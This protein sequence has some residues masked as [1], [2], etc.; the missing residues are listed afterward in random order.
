MDEP[1]T[2][3]EALGDPPLQAS[4]LDHPNASNDRQS[5]MYRFG[6]AFLNALKPLSFWNDGKGHQV[7]E[8]PRKIA[9]ERAWAELKA[10]GF[11]GCKSTN[12]LHIN[13]V[14]SELS[15]RARRS[16]HGASPINARFTDDL[17]TCN[18]QSSKDCQKDTTSS[19][20][21]PLYRSVTPSSTHRRRPSSLLRVPSLQIIHKASSYLQLPAKDNSLSGQ[22]GGHDV[23]A[24]PSSTNIPSSLR[25]E[26]SRK[27]LAKHQ[28]LSKRVSDLETQLEDAKKQL[29][30][31]SASPVPPQGPTQ[32]P[33]HVRRKAFVP[34]L[35]PSLPSERLI[36]EKL[37]SLPAR[38]GA[39]T[40]HT[41]ANNE[42][43]ALHEQLVEPHVPSTPQSKVIGSA[44]LEAASQL[45]RE[46]VD[47][48]QSHSSARKRK[49]NQG[50]PS[51]TE[52]IISMETPTTIPTSKRQKSLRPAE[53]PRK[54]KL[55]EAPSSPLH[56]EPIVPPLPAGGIQSS[57]LK[58]LLSDSQSRPSTLA[59]PRRSPAKGSSRS[60]LKSPSNL[61]GPRSSS[62]ATSQVY[63]MR[64]PLGTLSASNINILPPVLE[65]SSTAG[66]GPVKRPQPQT[67]KRT[68]S[69]PVIP[70]E[71]F[72]WPEDV[73]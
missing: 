4:N 26:P 43:T 18:D 39:S 36:N 70:K 8:D 54:A 15:S 34:G 9:A 68:T 6:R 63:G 29:R 25:K 12:L 61:G 32:T 59:P 49:S 16:I 14:D 48:L 38:A 22:H 52:T 7:P 11:E 65:K 56:G 67:P 71:D 55:V 1:C 42:P 44:T 58:S 17:S 53:K 24:T 20:A 33:V 47:S 21:L 2:L 10:N 13:G 3:R 40:R 73:F 64:S 72:E 46:L 23:P 69:T 35:L 50:Q 51:I 41:Q 57:Q 5:G 30:L 27:E 45:E 62:S 60:I 19:T 28:K 37:A 66:E 31:S